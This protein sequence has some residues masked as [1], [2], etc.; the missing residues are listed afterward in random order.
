MGHEYQ[1]ANS[2]N[3]ITTFPLMILTHKE[4]I[5]Y[6]Y[7]IHELALLILTWGMFTDKLNVS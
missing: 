6:Q 5:L 3:F 7:E 1:Q 2:T 4:K